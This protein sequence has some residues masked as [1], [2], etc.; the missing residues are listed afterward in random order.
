[1]QPELTPE[2]QADV[3]VRVKAF[4]EEFL[5]LVEKHQVDFTSYPQFVPSPQGGFVTVAPLS[6]FDKK[7]MPV[8]TPFG[9]SDK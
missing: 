3:E 1:M 5:A 7:Y 6:M 2:Q 4:K 8:K 9:P